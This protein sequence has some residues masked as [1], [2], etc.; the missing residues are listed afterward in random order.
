M[1]GDETKNI[2]VPA[3]V[4]AFRKEFPPD[5]ASIRTDY[6]LTQIAE[7]PAVVGHAVVM[8]LG[9]QGDDAILSEAFATRGLRPPVPG[10]QGMKDTRDAERAMTGAVGRA[11]FLMGY[12]DKP[13]DSADYEPDDEQWFKDNGWE[14][15]A[16]HDEGRKATLAVL[17]ALPE[18]YKRQAHKEYDQRGLA[19]RAWS[20]K[21]AEDWA[22]FLLPLGRKAKEAAA[23][24]DPGDAAGGEPGSEQDPAQ[25]KL[26]VGPDAP[27]VKH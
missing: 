12:G 5:K 22:A 18:P 23:Q 19:D 7:A 24:T 25:E 15:K 26:S 4:R 6:A 2:D 20:Q 27:L 13:D 1:R 11:L 14:S 21:E 16:Q 17:R 8:L 3:K 9:P 10:A